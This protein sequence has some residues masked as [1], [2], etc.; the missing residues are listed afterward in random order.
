MNG[1]KRDT[2]IGIVLKDNKAKIVEIESP[3]G[4]QFR[5][6]KITEEKLPTAFNADTIRDDDIIPDFAQGLAA[7]FDEHGFV[8]NHVILTLPNDLLVIKK[9]PYDKDLTDEELIDQ[10]DWEVK[11]FSYSPEDEYIIDFG[12]IRDTQGNNYNELVVVAV[13]EIVVRFI[14]E[15]FQRA[16]IRLRVVE[17]EV[18]AAIRAITKNY[19]AREGDITALVNIEENSIQFIIIDSGEY[20]MSHQIPLQLNPDD[21]DE[22]KSE[23]IVKLASKELKRIVIDHKLGEKIEDLSRI[24]LFGDV[25]FDS[26]LETLQNSYNVRID[27]ANPFRR[28]RFAPNVSVDEYIWSRPETFTICVGCALR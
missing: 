8:S 9:Y 24:F 17:A 12:K 5:I 7:I 22:A 4:E 20:F 21:S 1:M 16:N 28:L 27:R 11:Q 3:E 26:V 6:N 14:R 15:A 18:F 23:T 19:E 10:V 25:V 2:V 13:R